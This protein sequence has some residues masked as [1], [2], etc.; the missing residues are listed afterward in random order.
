[1]SKVTYIAK[2]YDNDQLVDITYIDEDDKEFAWYLFKEFCH[3]WSDNAY[4][5]IEKES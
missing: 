1:M 3:K 2:L 5:V 4:I